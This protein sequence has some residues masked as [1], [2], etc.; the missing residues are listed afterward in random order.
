[1]DNVT[2]LKIRSSHLRCK[3]ENKFLNVLERVEVLESNKDFPLSFSASCESSVPV[4]EISDKE[5]I[6][7]CY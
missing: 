3:F 4:K 6:D 2:Q 7:K 5:K 1:M